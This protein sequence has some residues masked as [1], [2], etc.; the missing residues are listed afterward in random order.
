M[1]AGA[2]V[3]HGARKGREQLW[4]LER[5]PLD[6]ARRSLDEVARR[7]DEALLRLK[8]ALEDET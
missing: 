4:S 8:T 1:L 7:W 5:A 3:A 2:G 6:E